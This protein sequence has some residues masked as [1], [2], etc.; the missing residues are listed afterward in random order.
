MNS[1][2]SNDVIVTPLR[3]LDEDGNGRLPG[4]DQ[5]VASLFVSEVISIFVS[6][7]DENMFF[8]SGG[9]GGRSCGPKL[10]ESNC[11]CEFGP[12]IVCSGIKD[13]RTWYEKRWDRCVR[14]ERSGTAGGAISFE[15][16]S[17]RE[18]D[19]RD[20]LIAGLSTGIADIEPTLERL[21]LLVMFNSGL[22][23]VPDTFLSSCMKALCSPVALGPYSEKRISPFIF[24]GTWIDLFPQL[25][26]HIF[27]GYL[28]H[29]WPSKLPRPGY[30]V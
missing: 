18:A 19:L 27:S 17:T 13:V 28:P 22:L 4:D 1:V 26:M 12:V 5:V 14:G 24:E 11:V 6:L 10:K 30:F 25:R 15:D 7:P 21:A 9:G 8:T 29:V 20:Q 16:A 2:W 23:P 3:S